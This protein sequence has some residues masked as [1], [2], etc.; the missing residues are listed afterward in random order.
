MTWN[1]AEAKRRLSELLRA[2]ETEPQVVTKRERVVAAVVS[3]GE[4]Q[5]FTEWRASR[6]SVGAAF[7]EL[8]G[9]AGGDAAL[10]IRPRKDRGNAFASRPR[11][12][13]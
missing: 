7:A 1:V 12:T 4:F 2:A 5:A 9:I 10:P 6:Q 8:R 3:A 11:R 13:R